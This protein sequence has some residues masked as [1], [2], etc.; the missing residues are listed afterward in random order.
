MLEFANKLLL[1]PYSDEFVT[2]I[3][4]RAFQLDPKLDREKLME[5]DEVFRC[6]ASRMSISHDYK[7]TYKFDAPI[8]L[9]K[10]QEKLTDSADIKKDLGLLE[11]VSKPDYLKIFVLENSNHSSII[12]DEKNISKIVNHVMDEPQAN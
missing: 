7:P 5:I 11:L 12:V 1:V 4:C 10:A 9:F 6:L 8:T 2:K 3:L